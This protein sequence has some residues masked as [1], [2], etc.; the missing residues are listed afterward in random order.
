M[1][2]AR[3]DSP[4]PLWALVWVFVPIAPPIMNAI[5]ANASQPQMA[6]LRCCALQRPA[7]AASDRV[8][9][10]LALMSISSRSVSDMAPAS[11]RQDSRSQWGWQASRRVGRPPPGVRIA[12]PGVWL[13]VWIWTGHGRESPPWA[14]PS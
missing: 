10:L 6:F 13:A 7:R 12:A 8:A 2:A 14:K 5:S 4:T 3:P 9:L 11:Q 1:R